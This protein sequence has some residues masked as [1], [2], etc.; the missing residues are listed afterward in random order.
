[1]RK[2]LVG[3]IVALVLTSGSLFALEEVTHMEEGRMKKLCEEFLDDII[4]GKYDQGYD[5]IRPYFPVPQQDF[6]QNKKNSVRQLQE[7]RKQYGELLGY[8]F[9]KMESAQDILRRYIYILKYEKHIVRW[10]LFFY[11]PEDKWLLDGYRWDDNVNA[12]FKT[13]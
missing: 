12:L 10:V 5:T 2:V 1:M 8:Q 4:V 11:K 7:A 9:V 13:S 3:I 6:L